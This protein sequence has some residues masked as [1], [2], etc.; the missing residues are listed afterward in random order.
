VN[1]PLRRVSVVIFVLFALLLANLNRL[2]FFQSSSLSASPYNGRNL[3]DAYNVPRGYI[4][5]GRTA[6]AVSKDTGGQLRYQRVYANGN[7][8]TA[9]EYAPITGYA[10]LVFGNSGLE[11]GEN[12][13]LN[14]TSDLLFARRLSDTVTG[15]Q[16]EG[17][18]LVLTVNGAAQDAAWNAVK[19]NHGDAPAGA[20]VALD[21]KTGKILAMVSWPSFDPNPLAGHDSDKVQDAWKA[22]DPD[23]SNGPMSNRAMGEGGPWPPGSTMKV[24]VSAAA[25]SS[26]AYKPSTEIPAGPEYT[27]PDGGNPIRND[28]SSICPQDQVTLL[29]ALRDSCNTGFA[30]LGVKLGAD[31]VEKQA[32]AFGLNKTVTIPML[33]QDKGLQVTQSKTGKPTGAAQTALTSIGQFN[34]AET[35]MQ[36]AMIASAVANDGTEMQPYLV[37]EIQGSDLTT[38]RTAHES[39]YGQPISADVA[40]QLRQMMDAVV[41]N[42]TGT[43][44]QID[45][46][47]VGGK[48][49]TAE[50]GAAG[51]EHGW[52]MGY[53]RDKNAGDPKVAVGVFLQ[54]AGES[55]SRNATIIGGQ[56][57]KAVLGVQ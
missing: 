20:A 7:A 25:L 40:G 54:G 43:K 21:P 36:E 12:S 56:I 49:G 13:V 33:G 28:V 11:Q 19:E 3:K 37:Q 44:A 2:Q 10:S 5:V 52:F 45:G 50:H 30:Q 32:E 23:S 41:E 1:H 29:T 31:A 16:T 24:I 39:T 47:E 35:P 18:N 8:E 14:G 46:Y 42:G 34:A 53:A 27:P 6:I 51:S 22:N 4:M 38:L 9:S 15:K 57:M 55:G 26:G 48:T 17:A